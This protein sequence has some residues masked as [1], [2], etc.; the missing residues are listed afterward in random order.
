MADTA[1]QFTY[2]ALDAEGATRSG[3]LSAP[4]EASALR[5][6][7]QGGLTPLQISTVGSA[8]AAAAS[9]GRRPRTRDAG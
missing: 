9:A 1:V 6:L 3:Q 7:I 8:G 2:R 4:D 5:E